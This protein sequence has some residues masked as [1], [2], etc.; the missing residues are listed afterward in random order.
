[1]QTRNFASVHGRRISPLSVQKHL[2]GEMAACDWHSDTPVVLKA[3]HI[4]SAA[5][6]PFN[7]RLEIKR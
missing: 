2:G 6:R 3:T 5:C 7:E 1:M 4:T